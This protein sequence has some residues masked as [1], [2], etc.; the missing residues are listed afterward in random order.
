MVEPLPHAGQQN[1]DE[2]ADAGRSTDA[3]RSSETQFADLSPFHWRVNLRS[4]AWQPPTDVYETESAI[5]VRVEIAGMREEDISVALNGRL[6]SIKGVRQDLAER[7]AFH[8]M[9]I[10]YGEFALDLELPAYVEGDQAQ[11]TYTN[12]FLR[13]TLPKAHPRQI[14]LSE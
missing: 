12:G 2:R 5:V 6:L 14:S 8:Q 7:R 11:A 13:V 9:E 3:G 10:R 4:P 1:S